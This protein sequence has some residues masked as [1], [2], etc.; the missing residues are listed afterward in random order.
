MVEVLLTGVTIAPLLVYGESGCLIKDQVMKRSEG[1]T[2]WSSMATTVSSVYFDS[3]DLCLYK[4]RIVRHEGAQ[5]FR[6]RWYGENKPKEDE[7]VFLELKTHHEKW[8][9]SSSVKE[10]V[11]IREK[12]VSTF[13]SRIHWSIQDAKVIVHAGNPELMGKD[14]DKA[15][16]LLLR[17]HEL[18]IKHNLR[19]CVRTKY[20]RLAFQSSDSNK[21]RLTV[22]RN[23]SLIDETGTLEGDWCIADS[24]IEEHMVKK[25]PH[26]VLEVKL[27]GC[28]IPDLIDSLLQEGALIE[29]PKF[30]KFLSGAAA[31][32]A[33]KVS[34]LPYWAEHKGFD[35]LFASSSA[36]MNDT[37]YTPA[38]SDM[39]NE[40]RYDSTSTTDVSSGETGVSLSTVSTDGEARKHGQVNEA[41]KRFPFGIRQRHHTMK[42]RIAPK[43]PARVEPKSYFA[44]ERTFIQWISASLLLVTVAVILLDFAS[45]HTNFPLIKVGLGLLG[46]ATFVVLYALYSYKRRV[47]LLSRGENYG[48]VDHC[49]PVFLSCA[50][51]TGLIVL[52]VIYSDK[53]HQN[54]ATSASTTASTTIQKSTECVQHEMAGLSLLEFEPSDILVQEDGHF[55]VPS[56]ESIHTHQITGSVDVLVTIPGADLEGLTSDD[57]GN[58]YALSESSEKKSEV[59]QL[60]WTSEDMEQLD[61]VGRSEIHTPK[62]E[63]IAFV[64]GTP[65]KLYVAGDLLADVNDPTDRGIIDVYDV[66]SMDNPFQLTTSQRLNSKLLNSGLEDSKISALQYFEGILYVL[67]DNARVVRAWDLTKG[68]LLSEWNLPQFSKQWEGMAL[69]RRRREGGGVRGGESLLLLHLALDSPPQVWSLA[70]QPGQT[71]GQFILPECASG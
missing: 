24:A 2:L 14:L 28:D 12:D 37:T 54:H 32:G 40:G 21:L 45:Q 20:Q 11:N 41:L 42:P 43:R 27:A 70:I 53:L 65:N 59:L 63:G 67:H 39:P 38:F 60:A 22:D 61:I 26:D 56:V 51:C 71:R 36:T 4:E 15:V 8:I 55:L 6:I 57:Q 5:L 58:I 3:P 18:V 66:P 29:A 52:L 33:T 23:I 64:P 1:D 48:Y 35:S 50:L 19:P 30:S 10:R 69:E 17:M 31:F 7:L 68:E 46:C 49:G 9:N 47:Q 44:N 25:V 34:L 16:D 62:A 13:L